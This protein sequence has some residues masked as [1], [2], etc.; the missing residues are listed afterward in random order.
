M[1]IMI[2]R[3]MHNMD[4]YSVFVR[5]E[6]RLRDWNQEELANRAEVSRMTVQKFERGGNIR[7]DILDKILAALGYRL[8]PEKIEENH[9][10]Q[11]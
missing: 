10:N 9:E 8:V 5:R 2:N 11:N 6:R 1:L 3:R 7:I 4:Y